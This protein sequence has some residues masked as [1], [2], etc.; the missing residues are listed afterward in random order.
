MSGTVKKVYRCPACGKTT[1]LD[2]CD[3]GHCTWMRCRDEKA[4]DLVMD[5]R[6]GRGHRLG[7]VNPAT[8]LRPRVRWVKP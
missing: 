4:C 7:D 2:H 8:N 1:F 5:Q 6:T 3:N